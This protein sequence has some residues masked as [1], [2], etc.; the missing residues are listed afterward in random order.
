MG[1][2]AGGFELQEADLPGRQGRLLLALLVIRRSHPL[3]R[4]A[5][6]EHLWPAERPRSWD[7]ALSA[8][9]SKL[10]QRLEA[11]PPS[12]SAGIRT[13]FGAHQLFLPADAWVDVECAPN[14]LDEAEAALR[15]GDLNG[16]WVA[17]HTTWS[18]TRRP[19]L[20]GEDTPWAGAFRD[21]LDGLRIRALNCIADVWSARDELELAESCATEAISIEPLREEGYRRLMEI[22]V[23][24]GNPA[25]ALETYE[26]CRRLLAAELGAR[27]GAATEA[28]YQ[29]VLAMT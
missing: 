3:T 14:R 26:R 27:P 24:R 16:A 22:R 19:F 21:R 5:L 23:R 10:R 11:L 13:A 6:A 2:E 17:A 4:D 7:V 18:I 9:V 12:R 29:R 20:V 28:L 1:I 15:D 8:L 25:A